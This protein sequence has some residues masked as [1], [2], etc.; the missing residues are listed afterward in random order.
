VDMFVGLAI[1]ILLATVISGFII[2]VVSKLGLGLHA[3]SFGWAML[4]GL[5]VGL[6]TNLIVQVVP[7]S[8]DIVSLVVSVVVSAAAIFL[9]GSLLRGVTVNG[10]AGALIAAIAITVIGFFLVLLIVGG[11]MAIGQPG[12]P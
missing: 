6:A 9:S 7:A 1:G 3:D 11:A 4:A 10:F 8:N 12:N 5:L 2:W